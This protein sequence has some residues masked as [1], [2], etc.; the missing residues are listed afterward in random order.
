MSGR[1]ID[2]TTMAAGIAAIVVGIVLAL[3]QEGTIDLAAGW[4]IVLACAAAGVVL[5]VDGVVRHDD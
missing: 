3:D 1:R 5:V 4:V 2:A